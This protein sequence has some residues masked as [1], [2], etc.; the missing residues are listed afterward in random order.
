MAVAKGKKTRASASQTV[1]AMFIEVPIYAVLVIAYFFLVLHFLGDWLGRE[2]KE[3]A[4]LY[5]FTAVGLI[6]GQAIV[7]EF[8]T[9]FLLRLLQGGR[10]E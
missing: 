9:T 4:L 6:V 3:H 10:S 8:V 5:A 2:H 1:R 7:L